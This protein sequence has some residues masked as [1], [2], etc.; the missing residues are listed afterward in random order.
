MIPKDA[1]HTNTL[2]YLHGLGSGPDKYIERFDSGNI[3]PPGF[4]VVL[5]Q[6]ALRATTFMK[7][8]KCPSWFDIFK[9]DGTS[10]YE[11]YDG[12]ITQNM[13]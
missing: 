13:N 6:A 10:E 1:E 9:M 8:T 4:K 12:D 3:A 7:G 11:S 2:I 5:P